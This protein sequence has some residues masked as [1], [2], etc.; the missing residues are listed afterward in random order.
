MIRRIIKFL[1][2]PI[3]ALLFFVLLVL[4]TFSLVTGN[5]ES[6]DPV[7]A[8]PSSGRFI[9]SG[10]LNIFIQESGRPE[11]IPVLL[12]HG[13]GAWSEIWRETMD[14]LA[15]SGFRAIAIDVPPFGYSDKPDGA[16]SYTR[17]K[18]AERIV[19]LMDL[20]KIEKIY[21][22]GHSVGARPTVEVALKIPNRISGLV[23]VDPALG[24]AS[25][26]GSYFEQND[27]YWIVGKLFSIKILR[28][29]VLATYA[30]NPM[31][32]KRLFRS[33]VSKTDSIT[34]ERVKI[35]QKPLI[36]KNATSAQGDW[37]QNLIISKDQS[38]G[39]DFSNF[40]NLNMPVLII[41]GS[42][43]SVTPLEQG[44]KLRGLI[45]DSVLKIIEGVGHIP[46]IEDPVQFN[47][48]LIN[49]LY[50]VIYHKEF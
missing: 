14:T 15:A 41:W 40:K 18:Q 24:F 12:V 32:T 5:R 2:Y 46:Y 16:E 39:S 50:N 31:F 37:L 21:L 38:L 23:L 35:M 27:P 19:A 33:F 42:T 8:A 9:R 43:D 3:G 13:T 29:S 11:G 1:A 10:D 45:P 7:D 49:S 22:V 20:L 30:T 28:N 25:D 48:I 36:L 17:E 4:V 34:D 44:E 6:F 47:N 26:G